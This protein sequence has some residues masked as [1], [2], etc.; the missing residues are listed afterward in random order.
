MPKM[1]LIK[2]EIDKIPLVEHGSITFFDTQMPGFGLRVGKTKK[3]FIAQRDILARTHVSTIG[4]YGIWTVDEA[5]QEARERLLLLSKG[6]DPD[7]EKRKRKAKTITLRELADE[8]YAAR[9]TLKASTKTAYQAY[10]R[11]HL[12]DWLDKPVIEI[13]EEAFSKKYVFIGE[14]RGKTVANCVKRTLSSILNYAIAAHRLMERNPVR[15][16]AETKAAY[17]SNRRRNYIRPHQLKVWHEAV[18]NLP[19]KTYSHF[20]TF[21]IHTGL[22]RNEASSLRWAN[23]DFEDKTFTIPDTK[24]GSPHKLPLSDFLYDLLQERRALTGSSLFVFPGPGRTG[25]LVEP[26]KAVDAVCKATGITFITH[27]LRRSFVTYAESLEVSSFSL[28]ALLNHKPDSITAQ[29]IQVDVN[30]L[31]KPMQAITDF[32]REQVNAS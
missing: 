29:Y 13:T 7:E 24:N 17:A 19:N 14:N 10:L 32:I 1:R 22:R 15:I 31:R 12:S 27:D 5:R 4:N 25:H 20:L 28:R 11:C 26:K 6:I 21:V 8:F 3:V 2:S 18:R 9:K 16:I 23:V 30:R